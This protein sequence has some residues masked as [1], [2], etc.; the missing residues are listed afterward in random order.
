DHAKGLASDG[1]GAPGSRTAV[2]TEKALERVR[3]LEG[4][5]ERLNRENHVLLEQFVRWSHNA[6]RKA[7]RHA[8]ATLL[9]NSALTEA[10]K[11]AKLQA[12]EYHFLLSFQISTS[13]I[14]NDGCPK[15]EQLQ[16][17]LKQPPMPTWKNEQY[18]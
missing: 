9:P 13:F 5:V 18:A 12:S 15:A 8:T 1:G 2:E 3:L 17:R 16:E 6:L 11:M 4:R 14:A 10:R 7:E